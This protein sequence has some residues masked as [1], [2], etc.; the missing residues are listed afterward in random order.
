MC[1]RFV[2]LMETVN[3]S[4]INV[5]EIVLTNMELNDLRKIIC[6][7]KS[8]VS[9]ERISVYNVTEVLMKN[10]IHCLPCSYANDT[11]NLLAL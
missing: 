11:I 4:S 2:I 8:S 5:I 3:S 10:G 6:L 7:R 9:V 1:T